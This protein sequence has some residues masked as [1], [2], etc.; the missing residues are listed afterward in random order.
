MK[1]LT[2]IVIIAAVFG[3]GL[4]LANI[5]DNASDIAQAQAAIEAAR[6]AQ[7]AAQ[8]A[9]IASGGL[10]A[11]S[12]MQSA[13]LALAVLALV[14]VIGLVVYTVIRSQAKP[15]MIARRAARVEVLDAPEPAAQ[16]PASTAGDRMDRLVD[17]MTLQMLSQMQQQKPQIPARW[18]DER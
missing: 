7:D 6:A 13:L 3:L 5:G 16:I 10:A 4:L 1:K 11:V 18:E 15:V 9:Q 14:A 17:L 12:M 2:W 8:A